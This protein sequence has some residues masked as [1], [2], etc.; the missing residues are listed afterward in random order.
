M[1]MLRIELNGKN[2]WRLLK[3]PF[4]AWRKLYCEIKRSYAIRAEE[5]K[6]YT[7]EI[8]SDCHFYIV[9]SVWNG[10]EIVLKC[11]HSVYQ[12]NYPKYLIKHILVD[13]N[14]TDDTDTMIRQWMKENPDNCVEYINRAQRMGGTFNNIECMKNAPEGSII[15][16][17]N[18]DDWLPDNEVLS[19][20]NHVYNDENIWI[21]YNTPICVDG[22]IDTKYK[23]FDKKTIETN[24]FR[25]HPQ[26]FSGHLHTF[27]QKLFQKLDLTCM[28]DPLNGKYWE[29]A[30]DQALYYPLFEMAGSHCVHI[31]RITCVYNLRD[32]SDQYRDTKGQ[33]TRAKRIK[34]LPKYQ[35]LGTL[36]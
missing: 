36:S 28:L 4:A 35:P 22:T 21:T 23:S 9:S 26:W 3:N 18:G 2:A 25:N 14:S 19:F 13:D 6:Y 10:G 29:N 34:Q 33:V 17:L 31:N 1:K 30:D 32:E 7:Q 24:N 12:Q 16:E 20:F 8:T 27:R 11:L 5:K 15:I